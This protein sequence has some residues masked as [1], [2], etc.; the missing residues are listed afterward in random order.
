MEKVQIIK[1]SYHQIVN[2][3]LTLK[4]YKGHQTRKL[5]PIYVSNTGASK[6]ISGYKISWLCPFKV[7]SFIHT[8]LAH[9]QGNYHPVILEIRMGPSRGGGGGGGIRGAPEFNSQI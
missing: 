3:H 5:F 6:K 8:I 4:D 1:F 2:L 7:W 9:T